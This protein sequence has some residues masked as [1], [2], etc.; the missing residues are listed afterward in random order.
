MGKKKWTI[1]EMAKLFD[2]SADTLRYYEKAGL[3]PSHK[4][5]ANGYRY[6]TYDDLVILMDILFFR[7]MDVAVKDI[8]RIMT[9]MDI[10]EIKQVIMHNQQI[11]EDNI[12]EL[13]RQRKMLAQVAGHYALCGQML[14]R[15]AIVPA[16]EFRCRFVGTQ[17]DDLFAAV[18]R[19]KRPDRR[20]LNQIRYTLLIPQAEL[21]QSRSFQ[22]AQL[23][24]SLDE[25]S[26]QLLADSEQRQFLAMCRGD[27][28]YTVAGTDYSAK[29]NPM[30]TE[31]LAWLKGQ[32]RR[33]RGPLLG[34][35]LASVHKDSLDYYEIWIALK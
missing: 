13:I 15:Y 6:Y 5:T 32:K 10:D 2:V 30:L 26:I 31:A 12:R 11:V 34:R 19:Y 8:R 22:G 9:E 4:N 29:A 20:W 1:G 27:Y 16:P 21:L 25:E 33:V 24:I 14:N 7:N 35:Y 17:D 3:M 18:G 23:G 28:L